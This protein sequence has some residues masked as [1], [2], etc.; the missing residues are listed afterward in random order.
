MID[1]HQRILA[2]REQVSEM[3][4]E[5]CAQDCIDQECT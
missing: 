5:I 3:Y 2:V 4:H 1:L